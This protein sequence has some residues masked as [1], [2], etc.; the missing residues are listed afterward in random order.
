M[1][2]NKIGIGII[3]YGSITPFHVK[4]I[5]ELGN[6]ELIGIQSSSVE[7]RKMISEE[8]G[9]LAFENYLDLISQKNIHLIIICTPSGFHL[10]P[11]LAAMKGGKHVVV[12]KPLEVT[13]ARCK[14]MI[15]VSKEHEVTLSCIFQN[16]YA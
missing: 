15:K 10:D 14:Q 9:V 7:K 11:V 5:L 2:I 4:S 13:V 1:E 16:R 8:L 6:C 3:G 12:E